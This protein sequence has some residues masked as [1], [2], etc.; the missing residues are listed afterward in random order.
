VFT[1]AACNF[2]PYFLS[3]FYP[4]CFYQIPEVLIA[5]AA[6]SIVGNLDIRVASFWQYLRVKVCC[7]CCQQPQD[8]EQEDQEKEDKG[9]TASSSSPSSSQRK[10]LSLRSSL[11]SSS[12][13]VSY[14]DAAAAAA[15]GG[16]G[17]SSSSGEAFSEDNPHRAS[18]ELSSSFSN[19]RLSTPRVVKL[20]GEVAV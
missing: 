2:D 3:R 10:S 4:L 20:S 11:T 1:S 15:A 13:R 16:V 12:L 7:D 9:T 8:C 19:S 6:M 14:H 18:V 5:L 17:T